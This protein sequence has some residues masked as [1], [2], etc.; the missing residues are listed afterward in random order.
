MNIVKRRLVWY[1]LSVLL[2]IASAIALFLWGIN[3]GTDFTG[4]TLVEVGF[5]KDVS[6]QLAR[7][8]IKDLDIGDVS[9]SNT[10]SNSVLV[11]AGVL[12]T[13]EIDNI[14]ET[15]KT[16]ITSDEG[17]GV[18][19]V[20]KKQSR[21]VGPSLG[22]DTTKR[23]ITL[24]IVALIAILLYIAWSFR[25]VQ[26]PFTSWSMSLTTVATVTHDIIV[27]LGFISLVNHFYGFEANSYLLV[28]ILTV[29]GYS[30]H[31]TIVVFDRI[32]ENILHHPGGE[33]IES[34]VERSVDQT[35]ARSLNT[36]LTLI[37]V[38]LALT[39]IGG[40]AIR[41]FVLTL[42]VG[43]TFGT[44]SSIFLAASILTDW[45]KHNEK[46]IAARKAN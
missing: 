32:R 24:T 8:A 13:G 34:I 45:G 4:G 9:V 35:L 11:K 15:L 20:Y 22:A 14:V 40:G 23:A 6:A 16:N 2:T 3:P 17:R 5:D 18:S 7:E 27:M 21:V 28:A 46:K 39:T 10:S 43:I 19:E 33:K 12:E 44:Y 37:L 26:K 29:L 38:L 30:I 25:K 31:D 36:S 41:P 42:L 1:I